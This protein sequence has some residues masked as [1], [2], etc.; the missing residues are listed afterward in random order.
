MAHF[1][2]REKIALGQGAHRIEYVARGFQRQVPRFV[3]HGVVVFGLAFWGSARSIRF[4][5]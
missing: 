4:L 5:V 2:E 1:A 3:S